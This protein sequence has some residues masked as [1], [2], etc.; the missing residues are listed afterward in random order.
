MKNKEFLCPCSCMMKLVFAW[1]DYDHAYDLY[2]CD[3]C[4]NIMKEDLLIDCGIKWLGLDN[5]LVKDDNLYE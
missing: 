4:G 2:A 5:E 3:N 1:E